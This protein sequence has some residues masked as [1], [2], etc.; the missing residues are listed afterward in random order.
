MA[1]QLAVAFDM[2]QPAALVE[3]SINSGTSWADLPVPAAGTHK[4]G[5]LLGVPAGT[6]AAGVLKLRA[7]GFPGSVVS[8]TAAVTVAGAASDT[9]ALA[10]ADFALTV[11]DIDAGT[12][13]KRSAL[14]QG[15]IETDANS[16][17]L[18]VNSP[19]GALGYVGPLTT[20]SAFDENWNFV[21]SVV[22]QAGPEHLLTLTGLPSNGV[23]KRY[24]LVEGGS[25]QDGSGMV[26][27]YIKSARRVGGTTIRS[28]AQPRAGQRIIEAGDSVS[29]GDGADI[30]SRTSYVARLRRL[31]GVNTEI[32]LT[33]WGG[34]SISSR[35]GNSQ[36]A[37][38]EA[39]RVAA[40]AQGATEAIYVLSAGTNDYGRSAG[41]PAQAAQYAGAVWDAIHA[42]NPAIKIV[43]ATPLLRTDKTASNG[44]G[45]LEDYKAAL[46]AAAAAR[47]GFVSV[48]DRT[49]WIGPANLADG[50]HP[51]TVGHGEI[52][53]RT[54]AFYA[55]GI[56]A[57][58]VA[59]LQGEPVAFRDVAPHVTATGNALEMTSPG[60][61]PLFSGIARGTKHIA[62]GDTGHVEFKFPVAGSDV[63]GGLA[64]GPAPTAFGQMEYIIYRNGTNGL[65]TVYESGVDVGLSGGLVGA[66]SDVYRVARE[67]TNIVYRCN[68]AAFRTVQNV[69][70]ADYYPVF[71]L[72][73]VGEKVSEAR[74]FATNGLVTY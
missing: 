66:V 1:N 72:N 37:N 32:V 61:G 44:Y 29:I 23:V 20:I 18:T 51:N 17:E 50:L 49:G 26:G 21:S 52:A 38:A 2:D 25:S 57:N 55:A 46:V 70:V 67:G 62:A 19:I 31:R 22:A 30:A 54:E 53:T 3:I 73:A 34:A 28:L 42:R 13:R 59:V 65:I 68:G 60:P 35:F 74:V 8:N 9:I 6:Y 40:Y 7:K 58:T 5:N 69:P 45:T 56:R 48:M 71:A 64:T 63:M 10:S 24:Y 43:Y 12:Y 4:T 39:D 16:L 47:P 11:Y 33:G 14:A 27:T 41:T 36:E 15:L